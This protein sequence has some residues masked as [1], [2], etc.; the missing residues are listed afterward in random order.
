MV[1]GS[2]SGSWGALYFDKFR[3]HCTDSPE[4]PASAW[5]GIVSPMTILGVEV[6]FS[7]L[8]SLFEISSLTQKRQTVTQRPSRSDIVPK[9]SI[10]YCAPVSFLEVGMC[11]LS[12][13]ISIYLHLDP[14]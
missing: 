3:R 5:G 7:H 14:P 9:G 13:H 8:L 10:L 2:Y 1:Q 11:R 6:V 4:S 12:M